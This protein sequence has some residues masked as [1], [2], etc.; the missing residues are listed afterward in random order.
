[1]YVYAQD[2]KAELAS[3]RRIR[4]RDLTDPAGIVYVYAHEKDPGQ[5][6]SERKAQVLPL[7]LEA[8]SF[9]PQLLQTLLGDHRG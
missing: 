5:K 9:E 3:A 7:P 6:R 1:M 4:T 8:E 2:L